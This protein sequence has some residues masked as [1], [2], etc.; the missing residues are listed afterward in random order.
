[1]EFCFELRCLA[2]IATLNS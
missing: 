1:M 2:E